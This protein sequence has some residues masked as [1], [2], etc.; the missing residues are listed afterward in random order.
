MVPAWLAGVS[1]RSG[2]VTGVIPGPS[3]V[4]VVGEGSET[5]GGVGVG[6]AGVG[7]GSAGGGV[8]SAGVGGGTAGGG[9]VS[10]GAG[11]LNTSGDAPPG[12]GVASTCFETSMHEFQKKVDI[13]YG[14]LVNSCMQ[15]VHIYMMAP[16]LWGRQVWRQSPDS[17][18]Q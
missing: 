8:G 18:G 7:V 3:G 2:V 10:A 9:V 1:A 12:A 13:M 17:C 16:H 15:Y 11:S 6:S 14:S 5:L 4:R